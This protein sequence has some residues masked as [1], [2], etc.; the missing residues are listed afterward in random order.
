MRHTLVW[1]GAP[2][3]VR[4]EV[5]RVDVEGAR[6][7]ASGTQIGI[8]DEPYE[9]RY[10]LDEPRLRVEVVGVRARE[11]ELE[12]GR[13]HFDVGFSPLFNSL[14]VLRH[15]LHRGGEPRDFVM[16]LV[17]VPAL[18]IEESHQGYDPLSGEGLVRFRSGVFE[19][20]LEF[21][22]AGFVVHYPGLA[23]QV[24]PPADA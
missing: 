22:D 2:R 20:D 21:D 6:L 9:L 13:D 1:T 12:N 10:E 15:G 18:E 23:E 14:P 8:A 24:W 5:A 7:R 16:T 4:L 3:E 11:L 19:A 17:S